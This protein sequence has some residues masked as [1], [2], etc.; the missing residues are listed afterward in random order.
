MLGRDTSPLL[1]LLRP[2]IYKV[3]V[4]PCFS[5]FFFLMANN[6]VFSC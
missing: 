4:L 5:S 2:R 1:T 3:G 6:A